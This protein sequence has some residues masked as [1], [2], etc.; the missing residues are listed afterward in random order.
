[1]A[2]SNANAK[3]KY[4]GIK[5]I[6]AND[7]IPL[8]M[9][10]EWA[11]AFQMPTFP[12]RND[13]MQDR[14]DELSRQFITLN[15][16]LPPPAFTIDNLIDYVVSTL[17]AGVVY[18]HEKPNKWSLSINIDTLPNEMF[19]GSKDFKPSLFCRL[20]ELGDERDMGSLKVVSLKP[21]V[22]TSA[23]SASLTSYIN[24]ALR[25]Y[26]G[27]YTRD[28]RL[29][30]CKLLVGQSSAPRVLAP[31]QLANQHDVLLG[32]RTD[33]LRDAGGVPI[34][35]TT[36][37]PRESLGGG[38]GK[39]DEVGDT[40]IGHKRGH[41][42]APSD[43]KRPRVQGPQPTSATIGQRSEASSSRSGNIWTALLAGINTEELPGRRAAELKMTICV[44][45][46]RQAEVEGTRARYEME[47]AQLDAKQAQL[48]VQQ[49]QVDAQQARLDVQQE[50]LAKMIESSAHFHANLQQ[51]IDADTRA[52]AQV[53]QWAE[54]EDLFEQGQLL[55][56]AAQP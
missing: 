45:E 55:L 37:A 53:D 15:K 50:T 33:T 38:S 32:H 5:A 43:P 52:L 18:W 10:T 14:G 49:A 46:D 16:H 23:H 13:F 28:I 44:H 7:R 25:P 29:E 31:R 42:F 47:R 3:A 36:L 54:D 26:D 51:A 34:V 30:T 4:R 9:P 39:H 2:D 12:S 40:A 48:E 17:F 56:D 20:L 35:Y 8:K 1:M 24:I 11:Y 6:Q 19:D 41:S 27:G 21:S 22:E